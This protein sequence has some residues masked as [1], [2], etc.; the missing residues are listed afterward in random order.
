M[1]QIR[2]FAVVLISILAIGGLIKPQPALSQTQS[3]DL[4]FNTFLPVIWRTLPPERLGPFGAKVTAVVYHP[5]DP[6]IVYAGTWGNGIYKSTNGGVTWAPSSKGL[7]NLVIQSLAISPSRPNALYAGVYY[8]ANVPG[9]V[10]KTIDGGANWFQTGRMIN[11]YAG[12]PVERPIVYAFAIHPW[13]SDVVYAGSRMA[14]LVPGQPIYGGGGVFKTS[15]GGLSWNPVNNGLPADDLYVY[16][17]TIDPGQ[18]DRVYAALHESGVYMTENGGNNW[19]CIN[20]NIPH[21]PSEDVVSS[22]RSIVLNRQYTPRLYYGTWHLQGVFTTTNRGDSWYSGGLD[23][24]KII[25]LA[26]DPLAPNILY[27]TTH[28]R[29]VYVTTDQG[30]DWDAV[31]PGGPG[32]TRVAI[33]PLDGRSL[34]VGTDDGSIFRSS[35]RGSNWVSSYW[36]VSGYPVNSIVADPSNPQILYA[37]LSGKGIYKSINR[38]ATWASVNNG[39]GDLN[40]TD[41][42]INPS[43]PETLYAATISGGVYRTTNGGTNW[44]SINSGYPVTT[45]I[46][47]EL[48]SSLPLP[49]PESE[50]LELEGSNYEVSS[51]ELDVTGLIYTTS[52]AISPANTANLLAGTA[53][54][55]ILRYSGGIWSSTSITTGTIYSVVF[56][57]DNSSVVYA[58]GA[59]SSGGLLKST[60]GG[61][62]WS[63]SNTGI[64]GRAVYVIAQSG[65]GKLFAGT[66]R[67]VYV[68]GDNG[69]TWQAYGLDNEAVTALLTA[70]QSSETVYAGTASDG[71]VRRMGEENWWGIGQGI[72]YYG[73]LDIIRDPGTSNTYY[74]AT[75]LGGVVRINLVP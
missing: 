48:D 12:Q 72:N 66:D 56:D 62:N 70:G 65:S 47:I 5:T 11:Y 42:V 10:F 31:R 64:S 27:A 38:G 17:V 74:F 28:E 33:N 68:S 46:S 9:G 44:G 45:G 43:T 1:K 37:A 7:S 32:Y 26:I 69:G 29:G 53:G 41:V 21:D 3:D 36:G 52:L 51:A 2:L 15:D 58:G 57:K 22:G 60:N 75:R 14:N 54:R 30:G 16:D 61:S 25:Y 8:Q 34:L 67:G 24:F 6:N 13:D 55:G 71:Y 40:V 20:S 59:A 18:P 73:V 19:A 4:P 39:L 35:D 23:G 63:V 50:P 49:I